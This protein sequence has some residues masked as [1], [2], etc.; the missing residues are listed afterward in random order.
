[1]ISMLASCINQGGDSPGNASQTPAPTDAA[2]ND[3][4]SNGDRQ[5]DGNLYLTGLPIVKEKETLTVAVG[6]HLNDA[7]ENYDEKHFVQKAEEETNM[8]W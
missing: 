7:T 2:K 1:M 4:G 5:M 8:Y 3:D 6:R